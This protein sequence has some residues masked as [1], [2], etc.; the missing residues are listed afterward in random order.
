MRQLTK[1][2][3][4]ILRYVQMPS[5]LHT[6]Q[7]IENIP[8]IIIPVFKTD[9]LS[10]LLEEIATHY[11][12]T[13]QILFSDFKGEHK[14]WATFLSGMQRIYVLGLGEKPAQNDVAHAFRFLSFN[15][16]IKLGT[17]IGVDLRIA[18]SDKLAYAEQIANGI[19][20]G[21]Y[22]IGLYK[23]LNG[24]T[25]PQNN[26]DAKI[27]FVTRNADDAEIV[28]KAAQ[29]GIAI[30]ETQMRVM[31]LV[32]AAPNYKTP[33]VLADWAVQSGKE[34]GYSVEVYDKEGCEKLG[35]HAL[36]SV[37]DGSPNEPRFIVMH[38]KSDA[39]T[40]TFGIVGKGV[41]FDS[42]GVS[43]KPSTNMH[44]MKSDMGGAAAV[45]GFLEVAAKLKLPYNVIGIVPSTENMVD[46]A[47]TKPGGVIKSYLGK[48]IEVIDTDAEGRLIL[49]DGLAYLKKNYTVDAIIDLATLTGS[50]IGT[51]GIYAA[52][53]FS[54][55]D[56]LANTLL[57]AAEKTGERL[58]R[59]PLWD[60]Y[61]EDIKSDVADVMNMPSR[62]QAG[63][64]YAAKFLEIFIDGHTCWAHLD[65]A[66][67]ALANNETGAQRV[68]T[69]FGIQLLVEALSQFR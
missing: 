31:T 5:V 52:G 49:A 6:T 60:L 54:N 64:T 4:T 59:L 56:A 34:N 24:N 36:L 2:I 9:K 18:L 63:A 46:G 32:N 43:I 20:L 14:E 29:R 38:Y 17:H 15:Q 44:L 39:A 37:S 27:E 51:L 67:M 68:A 48:T 3:L 21:T 1:N 19:L 45:L 50:V 12:R 61:A 25:H 65:I 13:F 55:N 33:E 22:H 26:A 30:A 11:G 42:G 57:A 53:L 58:W 35:L 10:I 16:K 62:A 40:K 7:T 47:A 8:V 41:T 23:T 28:V 69:G 66:G